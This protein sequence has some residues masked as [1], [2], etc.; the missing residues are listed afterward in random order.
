MHKKSKIL[1][2]I[3]INFSS[4]AYSQSTPLKALSLK[5]EPTD[6]P[7]DTSGT[8]LFYSIALIACDSCDIN[9][10]TLKLKSIETDSLINTKTFNIP[11]VDGVY[12]TEYFTNGLIR[13]GKAIYILL[14]NIKSKGILMLYADIRDSKNLTYNDILTTE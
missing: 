7:S 14:G 3:I 9:Q 4:F 12:Q 5:T 11:T 6:I 8:T 13:D 10:V 2:A 1:L